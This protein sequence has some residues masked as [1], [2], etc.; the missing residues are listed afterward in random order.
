[1][2]HFV[3]IGC[4]ALILLV[5]CRESDPRREVSGTVKLSGELLDDATIDFIPMEPAGQSTQTGA[6]I[7]E[8]KYLIPASHGLL[9][10]DYQIR[11]SSGDGVDPENPDQPPG[12][13]GN[14]V[15]NDRVPAEY[16][17]Q[18]KIVKTVTPEGP[19]VFDFD[20]P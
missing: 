10:G 18:S 7:T 4:C 9:P 16:N 3:S 15:M 20:I 8:G 2:R 13:T 12:P 19:N 11:I 14:Y 6:L 17:V 5:G 1:M